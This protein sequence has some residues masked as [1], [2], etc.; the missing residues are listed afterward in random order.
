MNIFI[1]GHK[2]MVGSSLVRAL[3]HHANVKLIL[4]TRHE[5]DLLDQKRVY[6]F[7]ND[8]KID[9]VY[10]A[11][12]K[13]GG[14]LANDKYSADF[15]YE[16]ITI[17]NNIISS[18]HDTGISKLLFLGSSCIYPK[19]AEQPIREESLLRG[20]LEKTNEGYAIAKIT[21]IKMC[22]A[23]RKQFGRDY[24][25]VMPT[26]LYGPNDNFHEENSHV[27]PGLIRRFHDSKIQKKEIV[28]IWGTGEPKREFLHVDD[29]AKGCIKMMNLDSQIFYRD[30]D[31]YS[32]VNLGTGKDIEIREL[33]NIISKVVGFKGQISFDISKPDG[34]PRKVLD[35]NKARSMGWESK[36]ELEEGIKSTY[37]WF[38]DNQQLY[39][40][41]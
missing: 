2:G 10:L 32:H 13:V 35:V 21:G 34:T 37:K 40:G 15:I 7:F 29:M 41:N 24:R 27:I 1:A 33:A 16:N 3:N 4:K 20:D 36:I 23:Y 6:E 18:S 14:I 19:F 38:V 31:L 28:K 17:Q 30:E 39:R 9:Q 26:N 8:E 25:S 5:L 22:E 12:A 11:A